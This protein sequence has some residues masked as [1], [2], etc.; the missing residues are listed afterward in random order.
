LSDFEELFLKNA[1]CSCEHM[2]SMQLALLQLKHGAGLF[3][4]GL[5]G[6]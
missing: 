4:F 2:Q 1:V 5:L 6:Q 3:D